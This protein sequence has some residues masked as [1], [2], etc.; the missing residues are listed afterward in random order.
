MS[1][2]RNFLVVFIWILGAVLSLASDSRTT[3]S[4]DGSVLNKLSG[5]PV[6]GAYVL[7]IKISPGNSGLATPLSVETNSAGNFNLR[8]E[9]GSYRLWV[10]RKGFARQAYDALSPAGEGS[11]ITLAPGQQIHQV[12]FRLVPLG[13]ITG[14]VLDED[15][16]PIQGAGI[17]VL[18]PSYANG[19]RQ[20]ISVSG[21]SSNDRG[22]YRVFGLP[23]GIYLMRAS[24]PGAPMSQPFKSGSLSPE[25]QDSYA[26][27]YYPGVLDVAAA[28]SISL[29]EGSEV[30]E[31]DFHVHKT[32]SITVR[33][34]VISP[35][36]SLPASQLQVIL[37]HNEDN[38]ASYIDRAAAVVDPTTGKFEIRGVSPGSYFLVASQL[39]AGRPFG[40]RT[41]L[42]V[43]ATAPPEDVAVTL[44]PGFD[45]VGNIEVDDVPRGNV[46][47]LTVRLV[48]SEGLTLGSPPSSR[49]GSDGN[50]RLGGVTPGLWTIVVD[51]LPPDMWVKMES[52]A[53]NE[54]LSG[55]LPISESMR[56]QLRIVLAKG[57][58]QIS[59]TVL[60]NGQPS[61]A[62]VVLAPAAA[63]LWSS[64]QLFKV[65]NTSE[66]GTFTLKGVPPGSYKL[67]GFQEI[68]PFAWF[69]PNV[70]KMVDGVGE[71]VTV[72]PGENVL[73]D[74]PAISPQALLPQ[75]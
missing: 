11:A 18:R 39:A 20:L 68:E 50:I 15:D 48:P 40:G 66:R 9:P 69:D 70:L 59:G 10:E 46:P 31:L 54:T 33:G 62:T 29:G 13:A 74:V 65:T 63:E 19:R 21:T 45:I 60:S 17:Q 71:F 24:M 30:P 8:L 34:H 14:R 32:L 72:G 35:A 7:Y 73:K 57:G 41:P 49:V 28:S 52:L 75:P 4:I 55:E 53:G 56:G 25:T 42:E 58:S 36:V 16:G 44:T 26:A 27:T 22:E 47:T 51:S 64:H 38:A 43:T 6:R 37:A 1:I 23:A 61:R 12:I 3:A 5:G 2:K 67:F